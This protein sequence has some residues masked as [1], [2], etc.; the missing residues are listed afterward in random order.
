MKRRSHLRPLIR[1][2]LIFML[3]LVVPVPSAQATD[4]LT[5]WGAGLTNKPSDN[6]DFGPVSYTHLTLPTIYSV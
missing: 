4:W 5:A 2:I 6:N 3:G 1:C